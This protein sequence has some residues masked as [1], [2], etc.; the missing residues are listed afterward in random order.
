MEEHILCKKKK[1][2]S[3]GVSKQSAT[4]GTMFVQVRRM[5]QL[6]LSNAGQGSA[7]S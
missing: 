7:A 6:G 5:P 4:H 3:Q 2:C 1:R